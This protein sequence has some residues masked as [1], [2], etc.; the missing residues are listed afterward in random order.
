MEVVS[1]QRSESMVQVLYNQ[2][3]FS[4]RIGWSLNGGGPFIFIKVKINCI[5][6]MYWDAL[7]AGARVAMKT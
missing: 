1:L 6:T 7:K 2:V 3:V 5:S 4:L